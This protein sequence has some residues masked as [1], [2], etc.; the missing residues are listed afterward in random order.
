MSA[1]KILRVC[2]VEDDVWV[3]EELVRALSEAGYRTEV[4]ENFESALRYFEAGSR[5]RFDVVVTQVGANGEG[6]DFSERLQRI[7]PHG[8]TRAIYYTAHTRE[9][10]GHLAD[11]RESGVVKQFGRYASKTTTVDEIVRIVGLPLM[12][13]ER[14]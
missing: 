13:A 7:P 1:A 14:V 8:S 12:A 9:S 10:F 6:F 3:R 2:V 5:E 11:R 4:F